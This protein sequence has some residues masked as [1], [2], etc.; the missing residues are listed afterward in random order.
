[1]IGLARG[2]VKIAPYSCE[3]KEFK[4]KYFE[5]ENM[6]FP[7]YPSDIDLTKESIIYYSLLDAKADSYAEAR[8]IKNITIVDGQLAVNTYEFDNNLRITVSNH[9]N[10]Q[11]RYV[12]LVTV[13]KSSLSNIK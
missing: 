6:P 11:H 12:I 7:L 13:S 5:Y 10:A 1:M 8:Q 9:E 2:T 4:S 3:W